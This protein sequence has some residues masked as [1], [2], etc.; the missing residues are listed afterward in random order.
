MAK[1]A[2]NGGVP[3]VDI[4]Y[5]QFLHPNIS[6]SI[7]E[8]M[9][10]PVFRDR[11]AS[12]DGYG[13]IAEVEHTFEQIMSVKHALAT[14]SGTSAL[15]AMYYALDLRKGD[16]VLVPAYTFFATAMPLFRLGCQPILSIAS[17]MGISTRLIS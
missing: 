10:D 12:F 6:M 11:M 3:V 2:I 9:T 5:Q 16:E 4:H 17:V 13:V 7:V 14:N 15:F 1:L 8:Q